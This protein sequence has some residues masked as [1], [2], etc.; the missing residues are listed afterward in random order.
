MVGLIKIVMVVINDDVRVEVDLK[1]ANNV[2]VSE[3]VAYLERLKR[4]L[5][6]HLSW[7]DEEEEIDSG[8]LETRKDPMYN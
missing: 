7:D 5:L 8:E 6:N 2:E 1:K 4:E 3:A